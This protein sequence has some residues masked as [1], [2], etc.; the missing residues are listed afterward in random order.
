MLI[1]FATFSNAWWEPREPVP[2]DV[3]PGGGITFGGGYVW[4]V[5]G[6]ENSDFYAYDIATGEWIDYLDDVPEEICNAGA[7]TYET[8]YGRRIFVATFNKLFVYTKKYAWGDADEGE[9]NEDN[10]IN[11]PAECGPGVSL[12]FQPEVIVAPPWGPITGWLYLLLGGGSRDFY[13]RGFE[14]LVEWPDGFYPPNDSQ[15]SQSNFIFDWSPGNE[16]VT[17]Q[18][19][20]DRTNS[21]ASPII[22]TL[23][24]VSEFRPPE[25]RLGI[26]TE[27]ITGG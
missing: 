7:I 22:D 26:G 6:N 18:F 5:I 20:L 23:I 4:C 19:Q 27:L 10:P 14:V 25:G 16:N 9:W 1:L 17:Y 3:G 15:I 2:D 24:S 8:G 13:R 21:F 11:L 12:A